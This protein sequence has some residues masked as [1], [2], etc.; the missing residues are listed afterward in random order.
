MASQKLEEEALR[1][2]AE[3]RVL[4]TNLQHQTETV[5]RLEQEIRDADQTGATLEERL[6][7]LRQTIGDNDAAGADKRRQLEEITPAR[8]RHCWTPAMAN[9]K[10]T[11]ELNR[12]LSDL[13]LQLSDAKVQASAAAS[14]MEEIGQR[15]GS[16][17]DL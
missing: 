9:T 13:T 14:S 10:E 3:I 7:R 11:T 5:E 12:K 1:K 2:D 16:V 17:D 15:S 6:A 8:A 4:E